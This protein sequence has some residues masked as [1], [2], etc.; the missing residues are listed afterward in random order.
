MGEDLERIREADE[1]KNVEPG[2]ILDGVLAPDALRKRRVRRDFIAQG[3]EGAEE[4]RMASAEG[5]LGRGIA[6]VQ[7]RPVQEYD[8]G[9]EQ[10]LVTVGM[11]A[12]AH[13]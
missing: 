10:G 8:A 9:A 5:I 2:D 4:S 11:G 7:D 3:F 1:R 13:S 12:A 6:G